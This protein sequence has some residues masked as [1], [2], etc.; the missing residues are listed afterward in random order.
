MRSIIA[1]FI[2][3][4]MLALSWS[5]QAYFGAYW[6]V[7]RLDAQGI[8]NAA[9]EQ[10]LL[11]K[12]PAAFNALR[13][14]LGDDNP[15]TA[16]QW[17]LDGKSVAGKPLRGPEETPSRANALR[18]Y[19]QGSAWFSHDD[20]KRGSLEVGKLADLAVLTKD[21]MTAPVEQVGAIESLLTMVGGKIVYAAG[22]LAQWETK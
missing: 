17:A 2:L 8:D 20:D 14:G 6:N 13:R 11:R 19:T 16:L 21:Y 10:A 12:G 15:F 5:T 18:A 1:T 4:A 3:I 22:P 7:H 9:V